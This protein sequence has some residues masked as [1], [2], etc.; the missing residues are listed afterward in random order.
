MNKE[1][2]MTKQQKMDRLT[3][4]KLKISRQH[5][6]EKITATIMYQIVMFVLNEIPERGGIAY[7]SNAFIVLIDSLF[8]TEEVEEGFEGLANFS[9]IFARPQM[10]IPEFVDNL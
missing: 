10:L 3:L 6:E 7:L 1:L 5:G 8:D 4:A 2:S 9:M